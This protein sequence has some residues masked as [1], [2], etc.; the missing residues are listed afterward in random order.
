[1]QGPLE[2]DWL[3]AMA[4]REANRIAALYEARVQTL[5]KERMNAPASPIIDAPK[6]S[7]RKRKRSLT[8]RRRN[9]I[10]DL[11]DEDEGVSSA[12]SS[13]D[14]DGDIYDKLDDDDDDSPSPEDDVA[15]L[16][17]FMRN[18]ASARDFR[19]VWDNMYF[20]R[21]YGITL[22]AV[23]NGAGYN[24][25]EGNTAPEFMMDMLQY[26]MT[27]GEINIRE[28]RH[29][30]QTKCAMCCCP[31]SCRYKFTMGAEAFFVGAKCALL[32]DAL[33]AFATR[34]FHDAP[35]EHAPLADWKA[36]EDDL[37]THVANAH[38]AH[39]KKTRTKRARAI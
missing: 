39:E 28:L 31:R 25:S 20:K 12:S 33:N 22:S 7:K 2:H 24:G 9:A 34:L 1:M 18:I 36:L 17:V 4:Q 35:G 10:D 30:I 32:F 8:S 37:D 38:D 14:D 13:P 15:E 26:V 11:E 27:H 29:T 5:V 6:K 16:Q 23:I 19:T 3:E 21:K